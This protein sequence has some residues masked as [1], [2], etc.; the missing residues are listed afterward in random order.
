MSRKHKKLGGGFFNS[1]GETLNNLKT[2]ITQTTQ[3]LINKTK[4]SLSS[5]QSSYQPTN[6]SSYQP[7]NQPPN[8]YGPM[9]YG[10]NKT[11]RRHRNRNRKHKRGGSFRDN[12]SLTNLASHAAPFSG[13]TAQAHNWVGG[14]KKYRR[15]STKRTYKRRH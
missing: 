15:K 4:Q 1:I 8:N 2:S 7:T 5:N 3:N 10:G 11:K 9:N 12:V 6:Q 14:K 13:N